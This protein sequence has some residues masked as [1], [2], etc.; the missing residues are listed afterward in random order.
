MS[1]TY[2]KFP[3]AMFRCPRG[4]KQAL[5][6]GVRKGAIP[7]DSWDDVQFDKQVWRPV[8]VAE[9]M[10]A[11]GHS[12]EAILKRLRR[13][14]P[15]GERGW[16]MEMAEHSRPKVPDGCLAVYDEVRDEPGKRAENSG[17]GSDLPM[18]GVG[19]RW[20]A[21]GHREGRRAW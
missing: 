16:I 18:E 5:V 9:R 15:V 3:R 4:R 2:K 10:R 21:C 11:K 20:T 17:R 1:R 19:S 8:R 12:D 6:A 7:P 13:H 14:V